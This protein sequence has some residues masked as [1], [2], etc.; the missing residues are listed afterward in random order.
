MEK[1]KLVNI[2]RIKKLANIILNNPV[3]IYIIVGLLLLTILIYLLNQYKHK[4]KNNSCILLT[5]YNEPSRRELYTDVITWWKRNTDLDI[6]VVNSYGDNSLNNLNANIVSFDQSKID[7]SHFGPSSTDYEIFSIQY[8][9]DTIK[10]L[11]NYDY[12]FKITGKYRLPGATDILSTIPP[13]YQIIIQN[14]HHDAE[15]IKF[16]WNNSEIIGFNGQNIKKIINI[17]KT[18]KPKNGMALE[19]RIPTYIKENKIKYYRLP[20]INIPEDFRV[21]RSDG[22]ILE[23][24]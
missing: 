10:E 17:L 5:M 13:G 1:K 23:K 19:K 15:G 3:Y 7:P 20:Q 4:K 2:T 14:S 18:T 8:A 21:K 12:V 9:V 24:L 6:Y 22:K 11:S 16:G